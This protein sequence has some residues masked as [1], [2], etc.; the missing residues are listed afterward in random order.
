MLKC[1]EEKHLSQLKEQFIFKLSYP[2]I[3]NAYQSVQSVLH[4][5][6]HL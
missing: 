4:M 1:Q 5:Y 2:L 6:Y 3:T